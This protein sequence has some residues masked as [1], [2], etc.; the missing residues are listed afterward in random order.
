MANYLAPE[1][2]ENALYS[3]HAF[4]VAVRQ[5]RGLYAQLY[6]AYLFAAIGA[7]HAHQ[8][9]H[10]HSGRMSHTTKATQSGQ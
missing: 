2:P 7:P 3:Q 1:T 6:N 5:P 8:M 9:V 4:F 10:R